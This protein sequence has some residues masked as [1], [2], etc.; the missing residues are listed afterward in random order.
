M[1]QSYLP[2]QTP[3][4]LRR[5]REEELVLLRGNGQGERKLGDRIYD[6]DVYNDL[7]HPDNSSE[8]ARPVLGGKEHPYPRRCRTGR[9][10]CQQGKRKNNSIFCFFD[11]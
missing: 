9:L 10:R 4:G 3:N 8:L 5:L 7:G 1:E 6:Y 2:S 11:K